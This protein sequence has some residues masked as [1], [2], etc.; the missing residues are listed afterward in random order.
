MRNLVSASLAAA[1]IILAS[2]ATGA[3]STQDNEPKSEARAKTTCRV[4]ERTGTRLRERVC[5][6]A[7]QWRKVDKLV[8]E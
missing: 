4:L 3:G 6:T 1:L 5:L 8:A 2:P 7:E